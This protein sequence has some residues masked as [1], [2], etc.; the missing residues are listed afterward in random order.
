MFL[1]LVWLGAVVQAPQ[2]QPLASPPSWPPEKV[3]ALQK[4]LTA[5]VQG[6]L[7]SP[8]YQGDSHWGETKRTVNGVKWNGSGIVRKPEWQYGEKNHGTWRKYQL[9]LDEPSAEHLRIHLRD[10]VNAGNNTLTFAL[11]LDADVHFDITQQNWKEGIKLFHGSVRGKVHF[12]LVLRC[13]SKLVL[14][15]GEGFLPVVKYRLRVVEAN[16]R[17]T[18]LKVTHLAGVGG[19]LAKKLGDWSHEVMQQWKPSVERKMIE[20]LTQKIMKAADTKEI[21]VSLSGVERK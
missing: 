15:M 4:A 16:P 1:V 19:E 18:G 10:V 13:E 8:L 2:A 11:Q 21:Q 9:T 17:Y 5:T 12:T 14:E 6:A 20:K 7:P 3:A